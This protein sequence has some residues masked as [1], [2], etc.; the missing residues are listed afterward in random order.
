MGKFACR[1]LVKTINTESNIRRQ[2]ANT[3]SYTFRQMK[4]IL[5]NKRHFVKLKSLCQ[6]KENDKAFPYIFPSDFGC[7]KTADDA[8]PVISSP[9]QLAQKLVCNV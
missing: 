8:T 6:I 4:Y 7:V 1:R 2:M 9:Y 5:S 3:C